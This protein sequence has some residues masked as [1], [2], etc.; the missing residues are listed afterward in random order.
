ML[1]KHTVWLNQLNALIDR[2]DAVQDK[3]EIKVTKD[4]LEFIVW[5]YK[6]NVFRGYKLVCK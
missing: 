3:S 2:S 4:M 1:N 5:K 6:T